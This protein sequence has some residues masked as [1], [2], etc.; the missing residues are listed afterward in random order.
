[1]NTSTFSYIKYDADSVAQSEKIKV[2]CEQ[3]EAE[4]GK[5][6]AGDYTTN[7]LTHLEISFMMVGKQIRNNQLQRE[8]QAAHLAARDNSKPIVHINNAK[9]EMSRNGLILTGVPVDHYRPDL[10]SLRVST[11]KVVSYDGD[12]VETNN[13]NY[14]VLNWI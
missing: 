3:L 13:T 4:I 2:L 12:K 9:L 8:P 7:A 11:S 14:I 5:L 10:N 1:M 6:G